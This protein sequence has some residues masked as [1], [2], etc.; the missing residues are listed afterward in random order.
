MGAP[1]IQQRVTHPPSGE[2][3]DRSPSSRAED[4]ERE[5]RSPELTQ[6][7]TELGQSRAHVAEL[8]S[9]L[10]ETARQAAERQDQMEARV[11]QLTRQL[12]KL[13]LSRQLTALGAADG[14]GGRS[15]RASAL[16]A[17]LD[18]LTATEEEEL[19]QGGMVTSTPRRVQSEARLTR[20]QA[21]SA[22][23][24]S[25]T[26][27]P[28]PRRCQSEEVKVHRPSDG[29]R[30]G[31]G[32]PRRAH[33][34]RRVL[35]EA[36]ESGVFPD[37]RLGETSDVEP[38]PTDRSEP[39]SCSEPPPPRSEPPRAQTRRL[40]ALELAHAEAT[41]R[42]SQEQERSAR[43]E[44]QTQELRARCREARRPPP[45]PRS[46]GLES[47]LL[48]QLRRLQETVGQE[49]ERRGL[50][51]LELERLSAG[52][53][54]ASA[55]VSRQL[56]RLLSELRH[57]PPAS[58]TELRR[59]IET[60][61]EDEFEGEARRREH[62]AEDLADTRR[63]LTEQMVRLGAAVSARDKRE[64]TFVQQCEQI[65]LL[66]APST[67]RSIASPVNERPVGPGGHRS[68]VRAA[69]LSVESQRIVPLL[70]ELREPAPLPD[71]KALA[72]S[73][74]AVRPAPCATSTPGESVRQPS[75]ELS[76]RIRHELDQSIRRHLTD[77]QEWHRG[78]S[79]GGSVSSVTPRST[80]TVHANDEDAVNR[81]RK[82]YLATVVNLYSL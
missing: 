50:L 26:P 67:R 56:E 76:R 43:L 61:F 81:S 75:A 33:C 23:G 51:E 78:G 13:Q 6:L 20:H 69:D 15:R 72:S 46:P 10:S 59:L 14:G 54:A 42:L 49:Q 38:P 45:T 80:S 2:P 11:A 55:R 7:R 68:A 4:A 41:L 21:V 27:A 22:G 36:A 66:S 31:G 71:F 44:Q 73:V 28:A 63:L 19:A 3:E 65:Q 60:E 34:S 53:D 5:E 57:R 37:W 24:Q 52:S 16:G 25:D 35:P 40:Q 70:P 79:R 58:Q 9:S 8:Q 77:D 30:R 29:R 17:A 82:D 48:S 47:A 39:T 1:R 62:L 32:G 18:H 74:V 64:E 12:A